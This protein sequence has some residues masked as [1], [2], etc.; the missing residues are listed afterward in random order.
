MTNFHGYLVVYWIELPTLFNYNWMKNFPWRLTCINT[1]AWCRG[2]WRRSGKWLSLRQVSYPV[3]LGGRMIPTSVPQPNWTGL[4][5]EVHCMAWNHNSWNVTTRWS[6]LWTL[7]CPWL[8]LAST[9]FSHQRPCRLIQPDHVCQLVSDFN[10]SKC[11]KVTSFDWFAS[12]CFVQQLTLKVLNSF[13]T[14]VFSC[15]YSCD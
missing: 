9:C 2:R 6:K 11:A 14:Y 5:D 3:T 7:N 4:T 12:R 13:I 10:I 8:T 15:S 1:R